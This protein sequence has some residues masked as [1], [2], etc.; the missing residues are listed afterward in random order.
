MT[1]KQPLNPPR[2]FLPTLSCFGKSLLF[3]FVVLLGALLYSEKIHLTTADLGRHLKNGETFL[4]GLKP[5][6]TNFYS[7]TEPDHPGINN[8][9]LTG[10][11]FFL[12]Q[13]WVGFEGLG[14]FYTCIFL[15]TIAI[16]FWVSQKMSN[17]YY[18]LFFFLISLP[19]ITSRTEI[20]PEGF[21]YLFLGIYFYLLHQVK[22]RKLPPEFLWI[23]PLIQVLW[24][25]MHIFFTFG[26]GI[27]GAFV[28]DSWFNEKGRFL[29]QCYLKVG[30]V[31][32]VVCLANPF[33]IKGALA[34]LTTF[35]NYGYM[36]AENQPVIF[37][38]KR[39]PGNPL[40]VHF[41]ALFFVC[42]T[43]FSLVLRKHNFR[44]YVLAVSLLTFFSVLSWRFIRAIPL[45][46]FFLV[47]F[48]ASLG[49]DFFKDR[50]PLV[51]RRVSQGLMVLSI[52]ILGSALSFKNLYYSPQKL[53]PQKLFGLMP[54]VNAS[55]EFFKRNQLEGPV[56]NNYDIGGYLI[57]HLFPRERVFVDNRPENYSVSFF[58]DVYVPMQ[59][60]DDVWQKMEKRYGFN[61][62]YFYRHDMTP[63]AQS[64]LIR[65]IRDVRWAPVFVDDY[66][67]IFLKRNPKN[68]RLIRMYELPPWMFQVRRNF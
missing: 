14:V 65:R 26:L 3:G 61:A 48:M 5:V 41:E 8:H 11:I 6:T 36:L 40:Y 21:S 37:M 39:M 31:S 30:F 9:W 34:P 19:L 53:N 58:K 54:G 13:K 10:V 68:A 17:F 51:N 24:V 45:F 62:I 28:L 20:R 27:V 43:G 56:F 33:G 22:T 49:H 59:E 44:K 7:Y 25:N 32:A 57:Y 1:E 64:F 23:I 4:T 63:W 38:Q 60:N 29:S 52:L 15:L 16:F 66:T 18:A 47:P 46:G 35:M 55:A 42:A 50:S 12:V 67:I 2:H